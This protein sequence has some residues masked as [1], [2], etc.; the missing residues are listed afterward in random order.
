MA[1]NY[2]DALQTLSRKLKADAESVLDH[3][4]ARGDHREELFLEMLRVRLG[5]SF[6]V[7][8]AEVIDSHG[9]STGEYDAVIYDRCTG[10]C[11]TEEHGRWLI[12]VESVVATVEIKSDLE[13]KHLKELFVHQNKEILQ[14]TRHYVPTW[15]LELARFGNPG[16]LERDQEKLKSGVNPMDHFE[17][18]P[19]VASFVFAFGGLSKDTVAQHIPLPGIDAVCVLNKYTMAKTKLG[20]SDNP[21]QVQ[22]WAEGADALGAFFFLIE[23][24]QEHHI[25]AM[26]F[27]RPLWRRYFLAPTA[28]STPSAPA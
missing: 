22:M 27:V 2:R 24:A 21:S 18:I 17:N 11:V 4:T 23:Q 16:G 14:L 12:R 15:E 28:I 1:K 25:E 20:Y 19:A 3:P 26:R 9:R 8:K 6:D 10:S 5:S 7:V 13:S